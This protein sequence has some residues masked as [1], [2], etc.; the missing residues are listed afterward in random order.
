MHRPPLCLIVSE[1]QFRSCTVAWI[2][3]EIRWNCLLGTSLGQAKFSL[4]DALLRKSKRLF[5]NGEPRR[6][7]GDSKSSRE[8]IESGVDGRHWKVLM[9]DLCAVGWGWGVFRIRRGTDEAT[10]E[11]RSG[12]AV[13]KPA[14][15]TACP[16]SACAVAAVTLRDCTCRCDGTGLTGPTCSVCSLVCQNGGALDAAC[17]SCTCPPG[18]FGQQCEGGY[19]LSPLAAIGGAP[20]QSVSINV[21]FSFGGAALPPTQTTFVGIY[22]MNEQDPL[23]SLSAAAVCPTF[24]KYDPS[25]NGGLCPALGSFQ[26]SPP[27][28]PGQYKVVVVP[29]SPANEM[30]MQGFVRP[31]LLTSCFMLRWSPICRKHQSISSWYKACSDIPD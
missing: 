21:V 13:V 5:L 23:Q 18:F 14:T 20:G 2:E 1:S 19:R 27:A 16:S 31:A 28:A 26:L 29:W 4:A 15:P 12:L 8:N 7:A 22:D 11:S 24:T 25:V 30:G 17:M 9:S 6:D 10:I 3:C